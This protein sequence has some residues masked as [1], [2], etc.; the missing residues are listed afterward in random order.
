MGNELMMLI[1][2]V[3]CDLRLMTGSQQLRHGIQWVSEIG[4]E[5]QGSVY[6]LTPWM[7]LILFKSKDQLPVVVNPCSDLCIAFVHKRLKLFASI[8]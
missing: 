4:S 8:M 7:P 6:I 1:Y 3:N 5:N 2:D